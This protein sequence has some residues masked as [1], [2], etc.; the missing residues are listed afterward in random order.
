MSKSKKK[1]IKVRD[2][3]PKKDAKGGSVIETSKQQQGTS[4]T[5]AMQGAVTSRTAMTGTGKNVN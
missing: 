4:V 5:G 2:L 3:N 1:N